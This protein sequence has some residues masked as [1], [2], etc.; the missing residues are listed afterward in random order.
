MIFSL[1]ASLAYSQVG[2]N[3]VNPGSTLTDSGSFAANYNIVTDLNYTLSA[4]DY[5]V[6]WNG[7]GTVNIL[8]PVALAVGSGNYR[9][10]IY[11]VKNA[12]LT[13]VLEISA[14]GTELLD[15]QSGLGVSSITLNPGQY[16]ML[17]SK[18]STGGTTT[19][20]VA[21]V[22]APPN[23]AIGT[24]L[25]VTFN[26]FTYS[27]AAGPG[28]TSAATLPLTFGPGGSGTTIPGSTI[29]A[30]SITLPR[31]MYRVS[32][33]FNG[34]FFPQGS[35]ANGSWVNLLVN[36]AAVTGLGSAMP[37]GNSWWSGSC[38]VLVEN[39]STLTFTEHVSAFYNTYFTL[40]GLGTSYA[41]IFKIQ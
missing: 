14:S 32:I 10:R 39:T 9:G 38:F 13:N 17:V 35:F 37:G 18:G 15:N 28:N 22:M 20:E 12:S 34:G 4:V 36:N 41:N 26:S 30:N 11:H 19:W 33:N 8:L 29:G 7:M 2:I 23:A 5:Y 21:I 40:N 31:G 3:T 24:W 27:S 6:S 16:A 25:V 1:T